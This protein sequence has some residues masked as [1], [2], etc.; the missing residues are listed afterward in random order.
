MPFRPVA[1]IP[2]PAAKQRQWLAIVGSVGQPRDGNNAACYALFD[3]D[4]E[5][6]TFY[7]VPYDHGRAAQKIL[8]AGLPRRLALRLESGT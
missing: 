1:G 8:A 2:I 5:R 3:P 6:L 4:R 7:R